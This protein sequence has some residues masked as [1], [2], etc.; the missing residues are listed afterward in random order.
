M[1][2][3]T[4]TGAVHHQEHQTPERPPRPNKKWRLAIVGLIGV[5]VTLACYGLIANSHQIASIPPRATSSA[6]QIGTPSASGSAPASG[7]PAPAPPTPPTPP[8]SS[9]SRPASHPLAVVSIAAFGPEGTADGDNPGLA[10]RILNVATDQPWYSQW[11]ATADF[12]GLRPGTG[13]LL[14]LGTTETV[15]SVSLTLGSTPG[16]DV[17][18]RVGDVP[19]AALPSAAS[20]S[21]ADGS[22]QLTLR[23][24]TKGRYV[25]IW[26]TRLPYVGDGHYQ[27][28]VYNAAVNGT[29][30]SPG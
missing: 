17:Q 15:T 7:H 6:S 14:D 9:A 12:G 27:V 20:A 3:G 5:Y 10:A 23:S 8:T 24:A 22:V 30:R 2:I 19:S 1:S 13:L 16:T 29:R 4:G 26:F 28:N 21:D 18:A 11:Y 25:L